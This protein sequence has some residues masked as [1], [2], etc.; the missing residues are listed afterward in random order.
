MK[1]DGPG[2]VGAVGRLLQPGS[3]ATHA[4]QAATATRRARPPASADLFMKPPR[5]P[6]RGRLGGAENSRG[7]A[8]SR[9]ARPI[10]HGLA[11]APVRLDPSRTRVPRPVAD[12]P[13][14]MRTST[15]T[16]RGAGL[17]ALL[18]FL[19]GNNFCLVATPLAGACPA[20]KPALGAA[21]VSAP[22][23]ACCIA[24]QGRKQ[25]ADQATREATAP[26]CVAI[27]ATIAPAATIVATAPA[28]SATVLAVPTHSTGAVDF[29]RAASVEAALPPPPRGAT[30]GAARAALRN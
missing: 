22:L 24:A 18:V 12:T 8:D 29:A 16:R 5:R 26:C 2:S 19:L 27:S 4:R 6:G 1:R 23:H 30:P 20:R 28:A 15:R 17:A 14:D 10:S 7:R 13:E 25:R 9:A 11:A 21:S 3:S